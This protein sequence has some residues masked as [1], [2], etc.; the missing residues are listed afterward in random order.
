L[1]N[2]FQKVFFRNIFVELWKVCS[3]KLLKKIIQKSF[4]KEGKTIFFIKLMGYKKNF[5]S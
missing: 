3:E 4:K 5:D 2:L 1:K